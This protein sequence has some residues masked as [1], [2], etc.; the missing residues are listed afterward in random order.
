MNRHLYLVPLACAALLAGSGGSSSAATAAE[1]GGQPPSRQAVADPPPMGWNSWNK[2]ACGIDEN[3]IKETADAI[4]D[5]GL[6]Q[7]GYEYVNIDDCWMAPE[8]D[9]DGNLQ[10]DPVRFPGG[11]AA[12]ADYVH[13]KG[14]KLGIYESAGTHTCE[15]L[16]GSLGHEVQDAQMFAAWGVDYL[17]YDNCGNQGLPA[18]ERY[19][20]M[21]DALAATGRKIIYS[22]CEWGENEPW[23]WANQLGDLWRTTW[24]IGDSWES[25]LWILDQQVGLEPFS[26]S[27]GG[28][29]DPDMLEVGNGG[30][31]GTEYRAH[32]SLW[33]LLSAPLMMGHDVRAMDADTKAILSNADVIEVNQDWG[34]SQGRRVAGFGDQPVELWVKPMSD[35]SMAAVLLN[36]GASPETVTTS[37]AAIGLGG[38]SS[39]ALKDLWTKQTSSSDG[40]ISAE[41]PA[42]GVVMYRISRSGSL[43]SAPSPGTH[44]VSDLAWMAESNGWGPAERDT[45]NGE[46]DPGDGNPISIAGTGYDKGVGAHAD[47]AVHVFLGKACT[48]FTADVGVDDEVGEQGS[49]RFQVYGDGRLLDW[50]YVKQGGQQADPLDVSTSGVT[51]LELRVT[52]ARD[53]DDYDHADWADA[54]IQC[55]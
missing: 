4:V 38:S 15:G 11:I 19:Q 12:L 20:A 43:A 9:A 45:S 35:G 42:H 6:A 17:K 14:L 8:R 49:V 41:V 36:W 48:R 5:E 27:S 10:A 31:T 44:Q 22:I 33:A 21:G 34:G 51:A 2:F 28:W 52:N 7:L 25:M 39:Y 26:G 29:N 18:F 1:T 50:S 54:K 16:P 23:L 46:A 3:L 32:F 13:A 55:G 53:G 30:M 37:A 24:D 47:S 40:E